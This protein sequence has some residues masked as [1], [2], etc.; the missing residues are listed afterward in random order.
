MTKRTRGSG[1]DEVDSVSSSAKYRKS[2]AASECGTGVGMAGGL[3]VLF[4][5]GLT[6]YVA[7]VCGRVG[8]EGLRSV[9][10]YSILLDLHKGLRPRLEL[11]LY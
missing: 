1:G 8:P 10:S 4:T 7:L 6:Y 5:I 2:S 3:L 9:L 11:N